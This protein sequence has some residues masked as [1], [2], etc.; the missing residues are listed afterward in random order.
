MGGRDTLCAEKAPFSLD[1]SEAQQ[2]WS[3]WV[4][5]FL[6]FLLVPCLGT[7]RSYSICKCVGSLT[8]RSK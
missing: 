2:S 5:V 7:C 8:A 1:S 4:H 3:T 6:V